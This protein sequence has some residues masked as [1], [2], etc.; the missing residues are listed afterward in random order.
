MGQGGDLRCPLGFDSLRAVQAHHHG[1][2]AKLLPRLHPRSL[3]ADRH[4]ASAL[5]RAHEAALSEARQHGRQVDD[6]LQHAQH[7]LVVPAHLDPQR[8]LSHRVQQAAPLGARLEILADPPVEPH[9]EQ[10]RGGQ[11]GAV[12]LVRLDL[13]EPRV[14]VA[15]HVLELEPGV[16]PPQLRGPAHAARA[17]DAAVRQVGQLVVLVRLAEHD[18]VP[19]V[20]ARGDAPQDAPVG[21]RGGHVLQAVDDHVELLGH[22]LRLE[23]RGPQALAQLREG[24]RLVPVAGDRQRVDLELGVR[25][26]L[27]ESIDD[28][29]G[30]LQRQPGPPSPDVDN[31]RLRGH[32]E[33][34]VGG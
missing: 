27:L 13:L 17:H 5:E 8:A 32:I 12:V 23:L 29:L 19:R 15:P 11:D 14:D 28:N 6:A 3:D 25:M 22:E 21:Q 31:D 34:I 20:L 24:R 26:R 2:Q 16:P 7:P 33:C 18:H 9:A 1:S 4:A 30:L 10:P